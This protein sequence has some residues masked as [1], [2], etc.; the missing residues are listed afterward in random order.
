MVNVEFINYE[1]NPL[2]SIRITRF[3]DKLIGRTWISSNMDVIQ[4]DIMIVLP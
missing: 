1:I 4:Y 3:R 2:Y